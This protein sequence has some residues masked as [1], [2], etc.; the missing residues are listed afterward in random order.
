MSPVFFM[1][2]AILRTLKIGNCIVEH[3]EKPV[4]GQGIDKG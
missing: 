4:E 3:I 2:I 1:K